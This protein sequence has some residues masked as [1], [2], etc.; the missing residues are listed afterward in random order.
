MV[1]FHEREHGRPRAMVRVSTYLPPALRLVGSEP[2]RV[3]SGGCHGNKTSVRD[4]RIGEGWPLASLLSLPGHQ[5]KETDRAEGWTPHV[6]HPRKLASIP[7]QLPC[8]RRGRQR[9]SAARSKPP[10]TD[11]SAP[12]V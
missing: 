4:R 10:S 3:L 1:A 5:G 9:L 11:S 6:R 8:R 7:S 2:L 12:V